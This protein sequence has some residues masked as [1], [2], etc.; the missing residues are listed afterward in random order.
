MQQNENNNWPVDPDRFKKGLY[1][2]TGINV[3]DGCSHI[4]AGCKNCWAAGNEHRFNKCGLTNSSG[5]W[6]G[7]IIVQS[8]R[9]KRCNSKKPQ[10]IAFWNDLFHKNVPDAFYEK[11]MT[12]MA[13]NPQHVYLIL[14]KR[15][16]L[17]PDHFNNISVL[18]NVFLGVTIESMKYMSRIEELESRWCGKTMLSIEPLLELIHFDYAELRKID[19]VVIGAESGSNKR[20]CD[21]VWLNSIVCQCRNMDVPVFVKQVHINGRLTKNMAEWPRDLRIRQTP[22]IEDNSQPSLNLGEK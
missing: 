16:E 15:P 1:W 10:V 19:W 8:Q 17:L 12:A 7:K 18:K 2:Q 3:I 14:T 20:S 6:T 5:K 21:L 4:S 11:L 13:D 22:E 9:L